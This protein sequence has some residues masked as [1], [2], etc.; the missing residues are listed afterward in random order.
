MLH[1]LRP[2]PWLLLLCFSLTNCNHDNTP[3]PGHTLKGKLVVS[4]ACAHY[5]IQVLDGDVSPGQ[6]TANWLNPDTGTN[7]SNVFTVSNR[8]SFPESMLKPGDVFS[9]EMD[10]SPK[11]EPCMVCMIFYPTPDAMN[12]VKNIHK[13]P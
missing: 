6:I 3:L 12:A 1:F 10:A 13:L 9:F 7:Y 2:V 11:P 4:A 8:C 5:V